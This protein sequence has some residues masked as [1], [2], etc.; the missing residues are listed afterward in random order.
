[1][2]AMGD[3]PEPPKEPPIIIVGL[4]RK[5]YYLYK[6]EDYLNQMLLADGDFPKP[7]L[8]VQFGSIFDAKRVLGGSFNLGS[9]WGIH[10]EIIARLR[11]TKCLIEKDV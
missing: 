1:M 3:K 8:C 11:D 5:N 9:M 10:P 7:V 4:E 6:G 2:N